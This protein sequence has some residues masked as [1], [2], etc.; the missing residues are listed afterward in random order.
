MNLQDPEL[1][2]RYHEEQEK[3]KQA[4]AIAEEKRRKEVEEAM[5]K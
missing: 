2:K 4:R 3:I 1:L 5:A